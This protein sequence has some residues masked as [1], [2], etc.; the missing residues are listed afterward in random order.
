M[1]LP[2]PTPTEPRVGRANPAR[3]RRSAGALVE[4]DPTG[5]DPA[6]R[7]RLQRYCCNSDP[8]RTGITARNRTLYL[9]KR[10]G[11]RTTRRRTSSLALGGTDASRATG[12]I[13]FAAESAKRR[14]SSAD[15][16]ESRKP[17]GAVRHPGGRVTRAYPPPKPVDGRRALVARGKPISSYKS[18][19]TP[20]RR[21]RGG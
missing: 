8:V 16:P 13:G 19:Y 11:N 2:V 9:P 21:S 12:G 10:D 1:K 3:A 4:N 18:V 20:A 6:V 14:Q 5:S 7:S 17:G 15:R